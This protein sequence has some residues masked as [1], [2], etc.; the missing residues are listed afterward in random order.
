MTDG[1][2]ARFYREKGVA[3][4]VAQ[5][6][7]PVLEDLGFRLVRVK[8]SAQNGTTVQ[9]MAERPDGT[10]TVEDCEAVSRAV[11]PVLDLEDP[12]AQAYHLEVSSPGIDRPLVRASD[13]R[14][15]AGYEAKIELGVPLEGRKR[16]RGI[17]RDADETT[18]TVEL[19]DAPGDEEVVARLALDDI[20]EARL[21]LTDD[22]IRESL[23]RGK[24]AEEAAAGDEEADPTADGR[25]G[26]NTV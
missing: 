13:F 25:A 17:V 9:I 3:A 11:S 19:P 15:W 14:R 16:F 26:Q 21:V 20:A 1:S 24:A 6:V 18:A 22:L 4:R 12:V 23:R 7:E 8:V 10:M 2:E 5:V